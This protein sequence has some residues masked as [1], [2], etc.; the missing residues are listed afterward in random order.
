MPN[1]SEPSTSCAQTNVTETSAPQSL[2]DPESSGT[3]P[4]VGDVDLLAAHSR[5]SVQITESGDCPY[6]ESESQ[7]EMSPSTTGALDE[8][9]V[10]ALKS[11]QERL[12]LLKLDR[13]FC[14]F[15]ENQSQDTIEFPWL[16]S[17]YR[18]MI[19]RSAIYFQL[20]RKVDPLLRRI[21]LSKTENSAM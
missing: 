17:Y 4:E 5:D 12:F 20:A 13:E 9:L 6:D 21:T 16:N 1:L 10:S 19:H 2:M 15:I 7:Q 18:M 14:N 11:R 3:S 8:F